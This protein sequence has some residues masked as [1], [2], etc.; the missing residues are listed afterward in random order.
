MLFLDWRERKILFSEETLKHVVQP[1]LEG[2]GCAGLA[3]RDP[4][5]SIVHSVDLNAEVLLGVLVAGDV[6]KTGGNVVVKSPLVFG[7][8]ALHQLG[9]PGERDLWWFHKFVDVTAVVYGSD[10]PVGLGDAEPG[11]GDER[12]SVQT[13]VLAGSNLGKECS[14]RRFI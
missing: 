5:G 10:G 3:H 2:P 12:G 8:D 4:G 13:L 9:H 7:R 14:L 6:I 1:D 11:H